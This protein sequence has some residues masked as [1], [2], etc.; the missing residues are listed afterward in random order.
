MVRDAV[1]IVNAASEHSVAA[2][3]IG[4]AGGSQ[5]STQFNAR[6]EAGKW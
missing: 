4:E 1:Q 3:S 2:R 6:T 5:A